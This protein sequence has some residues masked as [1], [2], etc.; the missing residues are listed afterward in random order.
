MKNLI[1]IILVAMFLTNGTLMAVVDFNTISKEE[2]VKIKG[3]GEKKALSIIEYRKTHKI[4][5][6][7]DLKN[8]KGFGD[9]LVSKIKENSI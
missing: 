9:K 6:V 2:L 5:S 3:I 7:D 1:F 8:I 4:E